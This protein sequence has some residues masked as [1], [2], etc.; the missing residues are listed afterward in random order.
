[1][2][3]SQDRPKL[4]SSTKKPYTAPQ[5]VSLGT[6][7]RLIAGGNSNGGDMGGQRSC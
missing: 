4:S 1:M 3:R 7:T 6:A 2:S 5:L